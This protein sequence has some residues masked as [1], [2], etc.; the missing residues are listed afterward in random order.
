MTTKASLSADLSSLCEPITEGLSCGE[1]IEHKFQLISQQIENPTEE[2]PW[3][4]LLKDTY[5]L[6]SETHD[7]RLV[8]IFTRILVQTE[9][10]PARGLAKGLFLLSNYLTLFWECLYP[11]VDNDDPEEAYFD[12]T[13]AL[14]TLG[15]YAV[16]ALQI[17][18]KITVI[19]T[20]FDSYTLDELLAFD[21][22][23]EKVN[24]KQAPLG[25]T[26][27]EQNNFNEAAENFS[28]AQQ[29]AEDIKKVLKEKTNQ[30]FVDFDEYLIPMLK[31]GAT[32]GSKNSTLV[33]SVDDA[34]VDHQTR[35]SDTP[36]PSASVIQS[37]NGGIHN[38]QDVLKAIDMICDYYIENEPSS[39]VPLLMQRAKK[40][41]DTDFRTIIE[42]FSLAGTSAVDGIFGRMDE[43]GSV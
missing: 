9:K 14:A 17:R 29:F 36:L 10:S 7:L 41:I 30:V 40:V 27:E 34:I 11:P 23:E 4:E 16:L 26:D 6:L 42:E 18:K 35:A 8:V 25:L 20:S 28:I 13:N 2:T 22:G 21:Q 43:S 24:G 33:N 3:R 12:R 39:P 15:G 19:S 32:I 37:V 5:A 31:D 38:R 1:N